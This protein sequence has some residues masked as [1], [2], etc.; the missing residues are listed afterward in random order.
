M[1]MDIFLRKFYTIKNIP[2]ISKNS[3]YHDIRESYYGGITEVYIPHGTDLSYLDVNSLYPFAALND[4]A[5]L[6]CIYRDNINN[7]IN[8][9]LDLFGFF[10]CRIKTSDKYI[11]LIPIRSD[12]GIKMPLGIIEG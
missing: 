5:G 6:N 9:C 12:E 10:Y 1:A 2:L 8:E 3:I 4:M 7:N 11:G